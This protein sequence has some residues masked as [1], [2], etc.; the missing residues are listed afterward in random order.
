M[1]RFDYF[2]AIPPDADIE[3]FPATRERKNSFLAFTVPLE[4]AIA[5]GCVEQCVSADQKKVKILLKDSGK[6]LGEGKESSVR[7]F[8]MGK[9]DGLRVAVA[10]P[11]SRLPSEDLLVEYAKEK[12]KFTNHV[13][14]KNFAQV[15][16]IKIPTA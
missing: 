13:Y 16:F 7:Q 3:Y 5:L 15:F 12:Q 6:I 2:P 1:P 4:V 11:C 10:S 14:G 8:D 9:P